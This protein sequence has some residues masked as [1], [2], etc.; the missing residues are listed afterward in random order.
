MEGEGFPVTNRKAAGHCLLRESYE[1]TFPAPPEK[2]YPTSG[3]LQACQANAAA[4]QPKAR[5][6]VPHSSIFPVA[7]PV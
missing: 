6:P 3:G 7:F 5:T 2:D 4:A 1:V